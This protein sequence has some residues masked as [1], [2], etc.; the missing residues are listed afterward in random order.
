MRHFLFLVLI[1]QINYKKSW[2][3]QFRTHSFYFYNLLFLLDWLLLLSIYSNILRTFLDKY[4]CWMLISCALHQF[5]VFFFSYYISSHY[6]KTGE[7]ILPE[8]IT[9]SVIWIVLTKFNLSYANTLSCNVPWQL[10]LFL[11]PTLPN[12][13]NSLICALSSDC[14][15]S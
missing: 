6:P 1:R 10:L 2:N 14:C 13:L 4:F 5:L 15:S 11:L 9:V 7:C 12:L 8:H 3:F